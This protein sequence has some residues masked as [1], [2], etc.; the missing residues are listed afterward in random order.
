MKK[1]LLCELGFSGDIYNRQHALTQCLTNAV[2]QMAGK[3]FGN[4]W[5][6]VS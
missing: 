3:C 5:N 1:T 6:L 4:S 2:L